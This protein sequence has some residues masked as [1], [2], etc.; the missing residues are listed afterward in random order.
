[1]IALSKKDGDCGRS[2]TATPSG[3]S[4][5]GR[6][7][8]S[9]LGQ[10]QVR[11]PAIITAYSAV[12]ALGRTIAEIKAKLASGASGLTPCPLSVPFET[13]C[14]AVTGPLDEPPSPFEDHDSRLLRLS[15]NALAEIQPALDRALA[16]WGPSR[17]AGVFGTSTG[18]ISQTEVAYERFHEEGAFPKQYDLRKQHQFSA[19]TEPLKAIA[20]LGGPCYWISTACSSSGKVI[21]SAQRLLAADV[22]DAVLVGGMDSLCHTTVRGFHSL[23]V[24]AKTPCRPFGQDRPGMNVGEG[25][26]F[27]LVERE[28][29]GVRVAGVGESSDA[30]HMSAPDPEGRGAARAMKQAMAQAG[31]GPDQIDHVNAHGT[32]TTRNDTAEAKAI[33]ELFSDR[34][35]VASTKGYTGHTLGAGGGTEMIFC[36]IALEEGW[37]PESLGAHPTDPEIHIQLLDSTQRCPVRRALSNSFAFGGNNF[38]VL[39][40]AP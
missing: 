1:M 40:E 27:L 38:C 22:A 8:G 3:L 16:R 10:N 24:M 30:F 5:A 28:G 7:S 18:G 20:G 26:A 32:G 29:T 6:A 23:G 33:F 39:L 35:P 17:V 15:L 34:V 9:A 14:G 36:I 31:V 37:L 11:P 25:A 4:K 19:T 21:A 12:N 13:V 2:H